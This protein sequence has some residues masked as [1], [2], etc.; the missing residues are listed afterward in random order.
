MAW[1]QSVKMVRVR[2]EGS[3]F[4]AAMA[5]AKGPSVARGISTQRISGHSAWARWV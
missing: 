4:I 2:S 3:S 5:D 1:S